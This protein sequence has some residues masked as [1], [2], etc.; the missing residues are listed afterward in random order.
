MG[1]ECAYSN[2]EALPKQEIQLDYHPYSQDKGKGK[3]PTY[4]QRFFS[5][6]LPRQDLGRPIHFLILGIIHSQISPVHLISACR[7]AGCIPVR[8]VK[9]SIP[10]AVNIFPIYQKVQAKVRKYEVSLLKCPHWLYKLGFHCL[11]SH[12]SP[13]TPEKKNPNHTTEQIPQVKI[14]LQKSLLIAC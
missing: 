14:L 12:T 9:Q 6:R 13:N 2:R 3:K 8:M 4:I 5:D 1:D 11:V 7:V 10:G